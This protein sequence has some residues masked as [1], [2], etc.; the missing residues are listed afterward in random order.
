MSLLKSDINVLL[1]F[2]DSSQ[3]DFDCKKIYF[4]PRDGYIECHLKFKKVFKDDF[5]RYFYSWYKINSYHIKSYSLQEIDDYD[6][7]YEFVVNYF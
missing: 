1:N 3:L 5:M 4:V 7:A 2:I 6:L